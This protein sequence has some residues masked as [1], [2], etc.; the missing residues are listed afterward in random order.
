MRVARLVN[1]GVNAIPAIPGKPKRIGLKAPVP[2]E[3]QTARAWHFGCWNRSSFVEVAP[4]YRGEFSLEPFICPHPILEEGEWQ[5]GP[6][7]VPAQ[8]AI[9]IPFGRMIGRYGAVLTNDNVLLSDV[10]RVFFREP[11]DHPLLCETELPPLR[12]LR[13]RYALLNGPGNSTYHWM[14]DNIARLEV[15]RLAGF[16]IKDF[17]GFL[18]T[19]P[20]YD[21]HY[22]TLDLLGIPRE[23]I[24]WCTK[25]RHVE[26]DSLVAASFPN[27][28]RQHH[29]FVFPFLRQLHRPSSVSP[30]QRIR[31]VISRKDSVRAVRRITNE[32]ELMPILDRFGFQRA[33]LGDIG[34]Q[35]QARLFAS[36][37]FIVA[38]HG[39]GLSNLCFCERPA[40]LLELFSPDYAPTHFRSLALQMG[41]G[42]QALVGEAV[43]AHDDPLLNNDMRID[44]AQL[45]AILQKML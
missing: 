8:F 21:P 31:L 7:T 24:V 45:E 41:L 43:P 33:T 6:F 20:K 2:V 30:N 14:Y 32:H 12:R 1:K 36:A 22:E 35:E 25:T 29:P 3:S 5:V 40:T 10:S 19:K 44:P 23:K 34:F 38:P 17:D 15:L 26:C 39:G 28:D 42:Y 4:P 16:R 13:G 11:W 37:E 18:M 27:N 9:E